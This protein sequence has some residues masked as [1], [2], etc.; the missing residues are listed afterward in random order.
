MRK[1]ILAC[2][3]VFLFIACQQNDKKTDAAVI[4][5]LQ[6]IEEPHHHATGH[7]P[8][9]LND[10]KPWKINEE[11]KPYLTKSKEILK[12]YNNNEN[13]TNYESLSLFLKEQNNL[14]IRSCTMTGEAHDVLHEWL[15]PHLELT[16]ALEKAESQEEADNIIHDLYN[17]F[18]DFNKFFK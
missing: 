7:S 14:L 6:Q 16:A 18:V 11:M 15:M 9:Y 3:S 8:L 5:D 13:D 2:F 4:N 10:G 12:T 1:I 17:S